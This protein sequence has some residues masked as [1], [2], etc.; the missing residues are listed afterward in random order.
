MQAASIAQ[1][2]FALAVLSSAALPTR[3]MTQPI[4]IVALGDST[5]AGTPA[6]KSPLESPPSGS[7]D[8]TSQYAFWL[9][10][11]HPEWVVLNRGINGQRSDE[12]RARFE[13]DVVQNRPA[14]TVIIAGVNDIYQGRTVEQVTGELQAMYA[15]AAEAGIPVVAGSIIPFNTA[16]REQNQRM[17]QVNE[18]IRR[19]PKVT[20]ADTRTA[21]AASGNPDV[22]FESPDNLHPSAAGYRRIAEAIAPALL[23]IL[24]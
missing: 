21:V 12:I 4:R 6:F 11:A 8:E 20:F 16:T 18:W 13:R 23:R 10:K 3:A 9:M 7:G 19:Q 5:T 17:R 14:A 24:R 22:L 1:V 2:V 15:R